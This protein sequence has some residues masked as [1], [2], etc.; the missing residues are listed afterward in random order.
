MF[1]GLQETGSERQQS[2]RNSFGIFE[3][4]ARGL[5][6][7]LMIRWLVAVDHV[8]WRGNSLD[9]ILSRMAAIGRC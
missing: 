2:G 4:I 6:L 9:F 3:A 1:A 7:P 8:G 5:C